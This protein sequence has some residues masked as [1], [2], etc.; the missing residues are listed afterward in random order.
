PVSPAVTMLRASPLL[1][2]YPMTDDVRQLVAAI[3]ALS[4]V[5]AT[6][7]LSQFQDLADRYFTHPKSG[8]HLDVW[9]RLY[10]RFPENDGCGVFWGILHGIESLPGSNEHVVASV[11][12][13]ATH[14]PVLMVNRMLNAGITSGRGRSGVPLLREVGA[15][16]GC[17]AG[18]R[19]GANRSLAP[20]RG[21]IGG[22]QTPLFPCTPAIQDEQ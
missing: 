9:F 11:R 20:H 4:L 3:D 2:E 8:D 22:R 19:G 21:R 17:S 1:R 6:D 5:E 12:R 7:D 14:F 16:G 15:G 13:K 10:E 18:A